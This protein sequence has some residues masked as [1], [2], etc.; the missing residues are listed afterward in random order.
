MKSN[1]F[2]DAVAKLTLIYTLI[3]AVICIGFSVAFYTATSN[4]LNRPVSLRFETQ[5]TPQP[6]NNLP[7]DFR[8]LIQQRD[9]TMRT[10][11]LILLI[12]VNAIVLLIGA[13]L[14]YFFARWTLQPI[15]KMTE[16]QANFISDAS[17]ELR[18]PLTAITMENEVAL[19]EPHLSKS[20]LTDIIKSNLDETRKL[21]SL[22]DRLLKLSQQEAIPLIKTNILDST[23][24]AITRLQLAAKTKSITIKNQVKSHTVSS[25]PETLT[26]LIAILL[27]NAIKFSS[28]KTTITITFKDNTLSI[29]DQG[30]GIAEADLPHI[31]DR[32]YRAEKSRTSDGYGLGLPLAK[33]L[34][35]QLNL[36]I[37]AQNHP[38]VGCTFSISAFQKSS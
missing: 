17:H 31:F 15:R 4:E 20:E 9:N 12:T 33:Q 34:A 13:G 7:S 28:S 37:S 3:L 19:R 26:D 2:N 5:Q 16:Q 11:L 38:K 30:P 1:L 22:T 8:D 18:T 21:Q 6:N 14:S 35:E 23:T 25:D 27:E 36:N 10:N 32:F 29:S 24:N